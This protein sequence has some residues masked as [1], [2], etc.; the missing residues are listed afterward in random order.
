MENSSSK[1]N[2][3]EPSSEEVKQSVI[4]GQLAYKNGETDQFTEIDRKDLWK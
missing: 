1:A 2:N 3:Q 4:D